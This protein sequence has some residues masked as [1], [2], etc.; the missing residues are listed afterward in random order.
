MIIFTILGVIV[1]IYFFGVML[2]LVY[3]RKTD[4]PIKNALQ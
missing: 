1:A 2:S 4:N 3:F